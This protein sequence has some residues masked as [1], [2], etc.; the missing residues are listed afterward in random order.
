MSK[1]KVL[2]VAIPLVVL[3]GAG[4]AAAGY[5]YHRGHHNPDHMVQRISETLELSSEQQQKLEV[6]KEAMVQGRTQMRADRTDVMNEII[7]EIRKPEIDQ[8]RVLQL[9]EERISRID[10]IA[11]NLVG[12]VVD[13][14]KSLSNEQREKVV[15][16]LESI[17]DWGNGH[18]HGHG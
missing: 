11:R 12:P 3:L 1:K 5:K 13:F 10:G 18:G 2:W 15:N 14:H 4:V 6:V 17:R 16:R 8:E 9:V 7:A